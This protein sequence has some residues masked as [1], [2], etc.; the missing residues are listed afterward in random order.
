M[1][2]DPRARDGAVLGHVTDQHRRRRR[3]LGRVDQRRGHLAD[4]SDVAGRPVDLDAGDGLH[5]V[6]DQQCGA[7]PLQLPE[8]GAEVGLGSQ[9]ER[10]GQRPDPCRAQPHL[11]G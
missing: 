5:G 3:R 1:L 9:V 8:D 4:L 7:D 2:Q 6:D 10:I 11:G